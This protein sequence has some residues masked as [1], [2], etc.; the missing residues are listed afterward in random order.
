MH[1]CKGEE[2]I[3]WHPDARSDYLWKCSEVPHIKFPTYYQLHRQQFLWLWGQIL[4]PNL[5]FHQFSLLINVLSIWHLPHGGD[6]PF[7][8][9]KPLKN[10]FYSHEVALKLVYLRV[11]SSFPCQS[12]FNH[13]S[14][15]IYHCPLRHVQVLTR[16]HIVTPSIFIKVEILSTTWHLADCRVRQLS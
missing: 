13:C 14:I 6:T 4:S 11:S 12:S 15:L 16:Q 9:R 8:L 7:K 2:A 5:H 10:F 1:R 3:G